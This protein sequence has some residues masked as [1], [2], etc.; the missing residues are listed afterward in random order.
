MKNNSLFLLLLMLVFSCKENEKNK[1]SRLVDEW[2]GKEIVFPKENVFTI[3]GKDTVDYKISNSEYKILVY[4]D[5][6]GCTSCKLQLSQ[7]KDFMEYADSVT[8]KSIPVLFFFQSKDYKEISFILRQND[9]SVPVCL[10]G[11]DRL[12]KLNKFPSETIF[13]TF[14]LD[15]NNRV[16]ALGNPILN[17][18]VKDLYIQQIAGYKSL[19][20]SGTQTA[21]K[22]DSLTIDFGMFNYKETKQAVF[23][24][25][26][27]GKA[28][29]AISDITTT[30]GCTATEYDKH[31][32][33]PGDSLQVKV[34]MT[35][36]SD[37]FFEES[38]TV[39]CN[40][41]PSF[42]KLSIKGHAF[43]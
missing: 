43:K 33:A 42:V 17:L 25:H 5:S 15:N 34:Q 6:L 39:R 41:N 13:Q 27:T 20:S 37:G 9:F 22:V 12:N 4:V 28:P 3:Y 35:P 14:L 38:I 19:S 30:C 8:G 2:Q 18:A 21:V 1:L 16:L 23:I 29:L 26:N 11:E 40:T 10:D 7:W 36:K 32:C 24:L 31:P